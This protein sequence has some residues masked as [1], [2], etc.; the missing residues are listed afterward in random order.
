MII[1]NT[2]FDW[3]RRHLVMLMYSMCFS[4]HLVFVVLIP[5]LFMVTISKL[6]AC[7]FCSA[8]RTET[9]N[10]YNHIFSNV[11]T[12][13]INMFTNKSDL[14]K[15]IHSNSI[16]NNEELSSFFSLVQ[17]EVTPNIES[18]FSTGS[19]EQTG[20][21]DIE[22]V[23]PGNNLLLSIIISLNL[24]A[25]VI[26]CCIFGI[27]VYC[28]RKLIF[29]KPFEVIRDGNV[30][31]RNRLH[32]KRLFFREILH[33][34]QDYDLEITNVGGNSLQSFTNDNDSG[35][36]EQRRHLERDLYESEPDPYLVPETIVTE[37]GYHPYLTVV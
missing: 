21:T 5:F 13:D 34:S 17:S 18:A 7:I 26:V 27:C 12:V 15:F 20:K 24:F 2:Y 3:N 9:R 32:E 19:G 11:S 16:P 6:T 14:D 8:D 33:K 1:I 25:I 30:Y 36:L 37:S 35:S 29:N 31:H 10:S 23:S 22:T 28:K 4:D